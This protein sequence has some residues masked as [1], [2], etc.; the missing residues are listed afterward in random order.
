LHIHFDCVRADVKAA[1]EAGQDDIGA[2]WTR[3]RLPPF[4][5]SYRVRRLSGAELAPRNPFALL[6]HGVP[7]AADD[8]GDFALAVIATTFSHGDPGFFLVADDSP[9][10]FGEGLLDHGCA[11]LREP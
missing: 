2:A 9:R 1:L 10:A 3:M 8:M 11:V 5:L 6:A 4:G 7:E